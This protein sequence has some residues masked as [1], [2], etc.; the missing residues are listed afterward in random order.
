MK[1]F[2]EVGADTRVHDVDVD[3][4]GYRR[5]SK[6]V[7]G[8]VGAT[9]NRGIVTGEIGV[10]Y[11]QRT[12]D[13]PRLDTLSA[14]IG[15]AWLIWKP[16]ALNTVK[17]TGNSGIGESTIPGVA[18]VISRD[19]G[20]QVDHSFRRWLIGTLKLGFGIDSYKGGTI[21][22]ADPSALCTCVVSTRAAPQRTA[23]TSATQP[24]LASPTSSIGPRR[25]RVRCGR[26]GC[27]HT[28]AASTIHRLS[29]CS[30][31][32]CSAEGCYLS[33]SRLRSSP[34]NSGAMSSRCSA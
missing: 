12:Y 4:A 17:L 20:L 11:T 22:P 24:G 33:P 28:S 18:G 30:G 23:R 2:V 14:L 34:R 1:P 31:C 15:Q 6:G 32:A 29:F 21:D 5:N 13:D 16:D 9:F 19:V 25:S 10:G 7:T 3:F 27:A 8:L 26:S